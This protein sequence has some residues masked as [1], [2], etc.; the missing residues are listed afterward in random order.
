M[1]HV[2]VS[3]TGTGSHP[4]RESFG[5]FKVSAIQ[6]YL[7]A[8]PHLKPVKSECAHMSSTKTVAKEPGDH[9]S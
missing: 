1:I 8:F 7:Q 4:K 6:S 2:Y 9:F 5:K 3:G